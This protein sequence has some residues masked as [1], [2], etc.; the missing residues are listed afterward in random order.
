LKAAGADLVVVVG[1]IPGSTDST[2]AV[3][4][5]LADVAR[6]MDG[7]A[8]AVLGG[9]SHNRLNGV[10]DGTPVLISGSHGTT[11]GRIDF[12]IDRAAMKPI[13]SETRR[14]LIT[15]FADEPAPDST[16]AAYVDSVNAHLVPMTSRVL[17]RS[18]DALVRNRQGESALG[19][20]VTDAMRAAA[21][22]DFAFQNPGG[23]RAD[24]DAGDVTMG[25]VYEVMPFDNQV[26]TVTLT[27]AQ[28]LDLLEK[29]L[30]P[31]G[32][33]QMSGLSVVYDPDRP[34]GER[35]LEIKLPGGKKLDPG[36]KYKVA[37]NDFMAQGG[38]GFDMLAKGDNL[39]LP[40]LLVRDL[41]IADVERRTKAGQVLAAPT[42]GRI[43]N[44]SAKVP[45]A[46]ANR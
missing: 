33:V 25:D 40:G 41:L 45:T 14:Q 12:V 19:D 39:T 24:L 7:R 8:I 4:G 46:D 37:T 6:A 38:D 26:A 18:K 23:L 10:V 1:H 22:A 11:L 3:R 9:H 43:V 20:W 27:G 36:A 21:G 16:I 35:V 30:S 34:R 15:V 5:E 28:V 42:P 29:G 2:G 31:T 44:R 32:C 13:A 17:G